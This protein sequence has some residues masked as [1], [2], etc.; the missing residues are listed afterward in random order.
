MTREEQIKEITMLTCPAYCRDKDKK[1]AGI[2]DCDM[3]CLH[4][5]RFETVY[6]N[7]NYR[8]QIEAEWIMVEKEDYWIPNITEKSVRAL[9]K[10][11][12]CEK[13][14]GLK[15]LEYSYCPNC[16]AKMIRRR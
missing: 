5:Q 2:Q 10:C 9:P 4:Y 1:C 7:A 6:D 13:E 16:G 15:A 8:K 14:F 11:S 12:N 3:R